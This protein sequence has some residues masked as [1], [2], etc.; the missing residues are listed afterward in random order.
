M[1]RRDRLDDSATLADILTRVVEIGGRLLA[2]LNNLQETHSVV[3]GRIFG[4][5]GGCW[6]AG[7]HCV[8]EAVVVM[9]EA[10]AGV[11]VL[12]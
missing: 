8:A 3:L 10:R 1:V 5:V 7:I 2:E 9:P 4:D 11:V 6:L 12:G